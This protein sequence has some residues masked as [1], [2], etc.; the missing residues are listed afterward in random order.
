MV[1]LVIQAP[2]LTNQGWEGQCVWGTAFYA[3]NCWILTKNKIKEQ[4][5]PVPAANTMTLPDSLRE[6]P[7]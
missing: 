2:M 6:V 1:E 4:W 5:P 7:K 3:A